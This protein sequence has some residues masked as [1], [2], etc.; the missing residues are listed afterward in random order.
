M[1]LR[2]LGSLTVYDNGNSNSNHKSHNNHNSDITVSQAKF[3]FTRTL[4]NGTVTYAGII[5]GCL[6]E[7]K[8]SR[9]CNNM[10][11]LEGMYWNTRYV[12]SW[13]I[14]LWNY[15]WQGNCQGY[16]TDDQGNM[17][18][19]LMFQVPYVTQCSCDE[20]LSLCCTL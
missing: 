2:P 4:Y 7:F 1:V 19:C 14:S 16:S 12:S 13:V 11:L 20:N 15:D 9:P 17:G 3:V 10:N 18:T 6:K 8:N 5:N